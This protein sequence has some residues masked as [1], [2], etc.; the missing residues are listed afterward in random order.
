MKTV[1]SHW[2]W[3]ITPHSYWESA[4]MQYVT[5]VRLLSP[6]TW[7]LKMI[8]SICH[9]QLMI[10]WLTRRSMFLTMLKLL[11]SA[12]RFLY[13]R[14]N[15]KM[16]WYLQKMCCYY[17]KTRNFKI[18]KNKFKSFYKVKNKQPNSASYIMVK[19]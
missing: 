2:T 3:L 9:V 5:S 16:S 12:N 18:K 4:S 7:R 6:K 10:A 17:Q 14:C 1:N 8:L 19:S 15:K 11:K 13:L